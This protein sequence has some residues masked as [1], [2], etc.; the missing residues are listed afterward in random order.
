MKFVYQYRT[1]QNELRDGVISAADRESAFAA[2]KR[3]GIR[4]AWLKEAPG[5]WNKLLGKGKRWIVIAILSVIVLAQIFFYFGG[6][7]QDDS[8][9]S[10]TVAS[11]KD[12]YRDSQG[13]A[14]PLARKQIWGDDTIIR[15][16]ISL[17]WKNLFESPSDL[18]L[19]RFAQP[20]ATVGRVAVSPEIERAMAAP[21]QGEVIVNDDDM[22]EHKQMKC[23]V[24]GMRNELSEY[25]SAGGS[26][27]NYI[28]R[29][30]DRQNYEAQ[31]LKRD[32]ASLEEF[33]RTNSADNVRA[34][35]REI[36]QKLRNLGLP[37]V[38]CPKAGVE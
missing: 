15:E 14:I 38:E 20:G 24:A 16:G 10:E 33:A 12:R 34:K 6:W 2:L 11:V 35:W 7:L 21:M 22:E 4:P 32:R 13:R 17:E 19:A 31:I 3:E 28:Q 25:L 36:N 27:R 29:L 9:S 37:L 23:I 8:V 18:L 30:L 1:S 26:V 5:F